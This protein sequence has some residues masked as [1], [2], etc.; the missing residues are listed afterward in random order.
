MKYT[1]K[2]IT[3]LERRKRA[4]LV[5]ALS[6]VKSA[7]LVGT[8]NEDGQTNLAIISSV[9]HLGSDPALL[10]F[11]QRPTSVEKHTYENIIAT[12][13][14]TFNAVE[15]SF[16]EKAHQTSAKYTRETSEFEAVGLTPEFDTDFFA[17]FVKESNIKIGLSLEE[18]IPIKIN[19]TKLMVGRVEVIYFPEDCFKE[20]GHLAIYESNVVGIGGL[21][22]YL[23]VSKNSRL[24][25]AQPGLPLKKL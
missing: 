13:K 5:N 21:D 18:I 1:V 2:D 6:G 16:V 19:N 4:H 3:E 24:S 15:Q 22:T 17:P 12:E 9:I 14:Y 20:D 11:I 10:G 25:Y 8:M 23:N 7:N